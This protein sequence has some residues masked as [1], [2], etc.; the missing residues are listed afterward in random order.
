[1]L[2]Q[3]LDNYQRYRF[4]GEPQYKEGVRKNKYL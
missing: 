4:V 2:S 3:S 1:M